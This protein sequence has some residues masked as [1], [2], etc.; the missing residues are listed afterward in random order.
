MLNEVKAELGRNRS[1]KDFE[2]PKS[3]RKLDI[4]I[5]RACDQTFRRAV[6]SSEGEYKR[7]AWQHGTGAGKKQESLGSKV[8]KDAEIARIVEKCNE[9]NKLTKD[10]FK[11]I[12][13]LL[14][15]EK[16]GN[17]LNKM[18]SE[19]STQSC[20]DIIR[21]AVSKTKTGVG[22][23]ANRKDRIVATINLK[24]TTAKREQ[25]NKNKE[26]MSFHRKS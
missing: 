7:P 8:N 16:I 18:P 5:A 10:D 25:Q 12:E 26:G 6:I 3:V 1:I 22:V 4:Q 17:D 21:E 15:K 19:K 11:S 13:K 23:T 9:G 14:K 20:G 24:T 2:L